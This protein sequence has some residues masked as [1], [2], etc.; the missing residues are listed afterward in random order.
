MIRRGKEILASLICVCVIG[1]AIFVSGT[2]PNLLGIPSSLAF[3]S[4]TVGEL[5]DMNNFR[6]VF[7]TTPNVE[8]AKK[9]AQ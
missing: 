1:I 3:S 2:Y 9:I 6:A 4:E 5:K 8:V 7:V